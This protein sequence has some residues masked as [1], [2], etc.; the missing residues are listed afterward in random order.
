MWIFLQKCFQGKQIFFSRAKSLIK[1]QT[2]AGTGALIFVNIKLNK[3]FLN[4][5][6]K[7]VFKYLKIILVP[8]FQNKFLYIYYFFP[9]TLQ[10]PVNY[11]RA[12]EVWL[13]FVKISFKTQVEKQEHILVIN[14][15]IYLILIIF[16]DIAGMFNVF[17]VFLT[18]IIL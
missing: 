5:I 12:L 7:N 17:Q 2:N 9:T 14:I 6:E 10:F 11:I 8:F 3:S 4:K 13:M 16:F 15:F 18:G 1:N